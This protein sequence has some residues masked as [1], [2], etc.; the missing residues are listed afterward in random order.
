[1]GRKDLAQRSEITKE[2][3][4]DLWTHN[5]FE[6]YSI[7]K[8]KRYEDLDSYV[9]T[10]RGPCIIVSSGPS[11]NEVLPR[12]HGLS[13]SGMPILCGASQAMALHAN[14]ITADF[15]ILY[16]SH[17]ANFEFLRPD[18]V[19]WGTSSLITH[20]FA[21]PRTLREWS[22]PLI[23]HQ[24]TTYY[25]DSWI[26]D[27]GL[28]FGE[29]VEKFKPDPAAPACFYFRDEY[30]IF[31]KLTMTR[32]I[33]EIKLKLLSTSCT[34]THSMTIASLMGFDPVLCVGFDNGFTH[35]LSRADTYRYDTILER[36]IKAG[37]H[38][39]KKDAAWLVMSENG[40]PTTRQLLAY[41]LGIIYHSAKLPPTFIEVHSGEPGTL[42]F[43]P[44]IHGDSLTLPLSLPIFK[45]E[46]RK[47]RANEIMRAENEKEK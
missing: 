5:A 13:S 25:F 15:I 4:L 21:D 16:D 12:I 39:Y 23:M 37:I 18:A 36:V 27:P 20:T 11:L 28:T 33:P 1:M 44:R 32:A 2:M 38:P 42:N 45:G 43:F 31:T 17:P 6:N 30:A 9:D 14:G 7:L 29:F 35:D 41:R 34:P 47:K 3:N 26:Q 40:V 19:D 24:L 22:G 46:E 8:T 10:R